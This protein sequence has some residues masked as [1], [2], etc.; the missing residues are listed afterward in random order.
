MCSFALFI[1][2][3]RSL[4]RRSLVLVSPLTGES[5]SLA[6]PRESNQREG[7]PVHPAPAAP[8][9]PRSITAPGARPD[10]AH[11]RRAIPGP[12]RLSRHPCRSTPSTVIPLGLLKGA[13]AS[14][15]KSRF[16]SKNQ[17]LPT[18]IFRRFRKLAVRSP[19]GGRAE[20][21]RRGASRMDAARGLMGQGRP[22]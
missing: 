17:T 4:A 10:A 14:S 7:H 1:S 8:G 3:P 16:K 19:S 11:R 20:V 15:V 21:L 9:F 5:L 6:C 22:M 18:L 12:S 13:W 2:G